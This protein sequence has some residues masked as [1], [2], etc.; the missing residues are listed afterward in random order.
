MVWEQ[1][2]RVIVMVTNLIE[3]GRVGLDLVNIPGGKNFIRGILGVYR[4]GLTGEMLPARG[5]RV[6][7]I[8]LVVV[9]H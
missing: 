6:C 1:N 3:K 9:R 4:L 7:F 5:D 2:T 8:R